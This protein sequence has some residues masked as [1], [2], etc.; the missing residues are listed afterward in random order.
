MR[1]GCRAAPTLR[2]QLPKIVCNEG[3]GEGR[4]P[5]I[6]MDESTEM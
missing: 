6:G 5:G 3:L 2:G 4:V 1:K